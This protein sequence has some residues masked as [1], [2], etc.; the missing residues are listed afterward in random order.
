MDVL[1]LAEAR[2]LVLHVGLHLGH[3]VGLPAGLL[4]CRVEHVFQQDGGCG[5]GGGR[6]KQPLIQHDSLRDMHGSRRRGGDGLRDAHRLGPFHSGGGGQSLHQSH[7]LLRVQPHAALA[8]VVG[9]VQLVDLRQL[10][11]LLRLRLLHRKL[12]RHEGGVRVRPPGCG[13]QR[14]R[15]GQ[16]RHRAGQGAWRQQPRQ[17]PCHTHHHLHA[18]HATRHHHRHGG[19]CGRQ[20]SHLHLQLQAAQHLAV[21]VLHRLDAVAEL[22][23]LDKAVAEGLLG[24]GVARHL[25]Q[26]QEAKRLKGLLQVDI[27]EVGVQVIDLRGKKGQCI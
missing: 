9:L 4:L 23:V 14:R 2:A 17:R 16:A 18:Q 7:A 25:H 5:D 12:L 21:P 11:L 8:L 1:H 26:L 15:T 20:R 22:P 13:G 10:H 6:A 3:P 27:L 19:C 24:G